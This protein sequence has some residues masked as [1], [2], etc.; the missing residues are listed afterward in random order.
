MPSS[1][2]S[3]NFLDRDKPWHQGQIG[4]AT[5]DRLKA[6]LT[7]G[8]DSAGRQYSSFVK[9]S[10]ADADKIIAKMKEDPRGFPQ[11]DE[12]GKDGGYYN[13]EAYQNWLVE[14]Y[15]ES[16][17]PPGL[18]DI[19]KEIREEKKEIKKAPKPKVSKVKS[20][21]IV[22]SK[23]IGAER[24]Q[25]Y[26]DELTSN[27]TIGGREL[28]PT[29]RKE[30]FKKRGSKIDF[31]KFVDKVLK[32]K[33]GPSISG[34]GRTSLGGRSAIVKS[35]I[36]AIQPFVSSPVSEKTQ[37]NLDDIMNGIDSI[38]K[39]IRQEQK[40]DEKVKR[41]EKTEAERARRGK[42]EKEL[43]SK[44]FKGLIS[45]V[46]K[47]LE[48]VKSLFK[49]VFDFISTVFLG[50][51]VFKLVEWFSDDNNKEKLNAIGRFL[52][53]T[54]PALLA[55]YILFGTSFGRFITK[56]V[57]MA[58]SFIF[59]ITRFAIPKL[60][61]FIKKNPRAALL[62]GGGAMLGAKILTGNES[63]EDLK[64]SEDTEEVPEMSSGGIVNGRKGIDKVP[65][66]LTD[67]E[68][69]MS[70]GAVQ[71]YGTDTLAAMNAAGGGTNK[72]KVS[73]GKVYA[74]GGGYVGEKEKVKDPKL[75]QRE[76]QSGPFNWL[77]GMFSGT[78]KPS[79]SSTSKKEEKKSGG[80]GTLKLSAQDFRDLAF[81]VSGEAARGTDDEYGVA[82]SI[83]N[84]VADPKWPNTIAAV[85]SQQGQYEAVYRGG[86]RDDP[87][88]AAKLA[89]PIGQS[90]IVEAL[91]ILKGRTDFKG[92]SQLGNKGKDDPMFNNRGNFFHYTSQV[93]KNDPPPSNP[94]QYWK[95]LV[96]SGGPAVQIST[97]SGPSGGLASLGSGG[98]GGPSISPSTSPPNIPPPSRQ[99]M[100]K[101]LEDAMMA[102][103]A[104]ASTG[105]N[106]TKSPGVSL[107][108][109]DAAVM[110]D[111]RK[112]KVLGM[113]T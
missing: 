53:D 22:P 1:N 46:N 71:K 109:F 79:I 30:G 33:A 104:P 19:L 6:R 85:G 15:L 35:P 47:T 84:R 59:K 99:D 66:M 100:R 21:A 73:D 7:G 93:G 4:P 8:K 12:K 105:Q 87:K 32:K 27:G 42:R 80:G 74:Q 48:P 60:F 39:T 107:P 88:L 13:L 72:P 111:S 44:T 41:D 82:A 28:S 23:F 101:M 76:K 5:W 17:E 94:P 96:G 67:G 36:G 25:A 92:Q 56:I 89:S 86:A 10:T 52:K 78:S 103:N 97:T 43:E 45:V 49:K 29:E 51:V 31:E 26:L 75:E 14:E 50:R 18:D 3:L 64:E 11:I 20:S 102:V 68:F 65:A 61:S 37:E 112:I 2:T 62:L 57:L 54:W 90:K 95:K 81:I 40:L 113:S 83:L 108:D 98:Q 91:K 63:A 24:Y 77:T 16:N 69:V 55:S 106:Y 34:P 70:R 9:L 58:G 110:H 38:L